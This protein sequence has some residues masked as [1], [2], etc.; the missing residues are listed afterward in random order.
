VTISHAQAAHDS[1][2]EEPYV[3]FILNFTVHLHVGHS[4]ENEL[5]YC[6]EGLNRS[7]SQ[8]R[9]LISHR[10]SHLLFIIL[11]YLKLISLGLFHISFFCA[12]FQSVS[13]LEA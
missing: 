7:L 10:M 13:G 11:I 6:D 3:D 4:V 8:L 2:D 1:Q 12:A 5:V 9:C